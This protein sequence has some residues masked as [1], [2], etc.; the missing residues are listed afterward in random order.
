M[1]AFAFV[2]TNPQPITILAGGLFAI[3]GIAGAMAM[4]IGSHR[5][6]TANEIASGPSTSTTSRASPTK[7]SRPPRPSG[8]RSTGVIRRR[9]AGGV[10][11]T[12]ARVWERRVHDS[13][14][15]EVRIGLGDQPLA[16]PL[17]PWPEPEPLNVLDPCS[18]P[19]GETCCDVM[20]GCREYR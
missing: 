13:D 8:A 20:N 9:R 5:P 1:G 12:R 17:E 18:S 3:A 7:R 16:A 6:D 15:L 14:F 10:V 2:A 19:P 11:R 4:A